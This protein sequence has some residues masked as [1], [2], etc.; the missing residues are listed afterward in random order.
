MDFLKGYK[1]YIGIGLVGTGFVLSA[2]GIEPFG[3]LLVKAGGLLGAYGAAAK[4]Q[5]LIDGRR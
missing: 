3:S 5:R 2:V 4:A 1:T